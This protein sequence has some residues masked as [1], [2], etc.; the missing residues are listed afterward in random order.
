MIDFAEDLPHEWHLT[1]DFGQIVIL[2]SCP[3]LIQS[4]PN[5]QRYRVFCEYKIYFV[6]EQEA[7]RLLS[8][9]KLLRSAQILNNALK[10]MIKE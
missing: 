6:Y 3:W 5:I 8:Q 7:K 10:L 9:A 2:P 4:A 1:T